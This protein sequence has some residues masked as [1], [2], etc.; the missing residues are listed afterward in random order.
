[1][2][3]AQMLG[4]HAPNA[5]TPRPT[6]DE[7]DFFGITHP[8]KVRAE[9]QDH[10]LLATIHPEVVIR[11]TSLPTDAMPL[12]GSRFGTFAL[13]ADGVGGAAAGSDAA[14]IAAETVARYVS[15]SVRALHMFDRKEPENLHEALKEAAMQ[16][17]DAVRAE[18]ASRPEQKRMATTLTLMVACWPWMYV[19]QVGDSRLYV[20]QEGKLRLVTRDQTVAQLLVDEGAM[21]ASQ[22]ATSPLHNVLASAIGSDEATPVVTRVD[23]T[24]RTTV[25]L[26]CS[27]GLTKHVKDD[28][29]QRYLQEM[30]SSEQVC[31][32]LLSLALERGGTD[33]VTILALR[34]PP[35]KG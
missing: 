29:I 23:V 17:H 3:L 32:D 26:L 33:N 14:R 1:M 8:G 28:E 10:F 12:R 5:N 2:K 19:M 7:L 31:N 25:I 15:E 9:N 16:A 18:A 34:S 11:N 4:S 20:L 35:K 21:K 24:T 30:K 6:D 13:V 27:D 22:L